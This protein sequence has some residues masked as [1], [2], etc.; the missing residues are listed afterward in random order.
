MRGYS[1]V[2]RVGGGEGGGRGVLPVLPIMAYTGRLCPTGA[3]FS[4]FR[5]SQTPLIPN[6]KG[7]IESV[8]IEWVGFRENVRTFF[9]EGKSKLSVTKRCKAVFD[10]IK[11]GSDFTG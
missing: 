11:K 6:T 5:Y 10:C 3:S 7:A 8:R 9:P 2:A 1:S 4:G